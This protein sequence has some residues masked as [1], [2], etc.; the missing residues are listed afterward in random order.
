MGFDLTHP[1]QV[2]EGKTYAKAQF[3]K[4]DVKSFLEE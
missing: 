4:V 3:P 1:L 2:E